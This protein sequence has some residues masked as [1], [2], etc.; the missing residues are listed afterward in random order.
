MK[1]EEIL[2]LQENGAWK[3]EKCG[4][5]RPRLSGRAK[6]DCALYGADALIGCFPPPPP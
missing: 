4:D 3:K 5:S 2:E 1:L 6:L